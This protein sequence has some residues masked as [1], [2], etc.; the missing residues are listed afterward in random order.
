MGMVVYYVVPGG[1][2]ALLFA[3]LIL[4]PRC[5]INLTLLY[6]SITV[7]VYGT[8]LF[9]RLPSPGIFRP[10]SYKDLYVLLT[11]VD[12]TTRGEK[13]ILA[14]LAAQ[15][16]VDVDTRDRLE[17]IADFRKRGTQAVPAI[18]PAWFLR[19][20]EETVTVKSP[21]SIA[22][23]ELQPLG[24]IANKVTVLCNEN[25]P[26][27]TYQSDK[28]GFHN[29]PGIWRSSRLEIAAVGDSFTQGH[30]ASSDKNFVALIR[31]QYPAT[32]NLAMGGNGPLLELATIKEYLRAAKP[33]VVLWFYYEG[34]DLT[35]LQ[36]EKRS[37]LLRRYLGEDFSQGLLGRQDDIDRALTN[38]IAKREVDNQIKR[39][40]TIS[41]LVDA[42]TLPTLRQKL[43]LVYGVNA[44]E[45]ADFEGP[46]MHDFLEILLKA[47][48]IVDAWRGILYFVYLPSWSSYAQSPHFSET[49]AIKKRAEV[50]YIVSSLGIPV[51]DVYPA[52]QAQSDPLSLFPFRQFGHYNEKGHRLVAREV[53]RKLSV[54]TDPAL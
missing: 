37:K 51:I 5:K 3:S 43:G 44:Q 21:I 38:Q 54:A 42:I 24:G 27:V 6:L 19:Q 16:G 29:P 50:L 36:I 33:N 14:N 1:L 45:R 40:E 26:W 34:N 39:G 10:R 13:R 20:G 28:Y 18:H 25:G 41:K 35:D 17:V 31:Q 15:F 30:C 9:L 22:G 49:L 7:F 11:S 12:R 23:V 2:A 46:I 4:K 47:K 48:T 8:E 52:F 32:L 53:L